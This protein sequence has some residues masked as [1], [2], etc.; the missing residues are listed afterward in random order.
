MRVAY[1]DW[2]KE[3]WKITSDPDLVQEKVEEAD[4]M[5][6]WAGTDKEMKNVAAFFDQHFEESTICIDDKTF[7][8]CE[9]ASDP[10]EVLDS[11]YE[12]W[13][14]NEYDY[15]VAH[16]Q[17]PQDYDLE[18]ITVKQILRGKALSKIS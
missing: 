16:N 15:A 9:N 17:T 2:D 3:K 14:E 10:Q 11:E 5:V 7:E 12:S 18:G 6:F 13:K 1:Y 8:F 4:E